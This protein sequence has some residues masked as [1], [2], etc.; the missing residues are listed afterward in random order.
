M[1]IAAFAAIALAVVAFVLS[2]SWADPAPRPTACPYCRALLGADDFCPRCAR[3]VGMSATAATNRFWGDV[4]YLIQ[5]PPSDTDLTISSKLSDAGIVEETVAS[6][7]GERYTWTPGPDGAEVEGRV[8]FGRSSKESRL[9]ATIRDTVLGNRLV[10]REILGEISGS[11]D[12]Y[13]RRTLDYVYTTDGL[14]SA[15]KFGTWFFNSASD[16]KKRPGEW[17]KHAVGEIALVRQDGR[18]TRIETTVREGRRSLRGEPEYMEPKT[19][20]ESAQ[21][22]A[23]GAIDRLVKTTRPEESR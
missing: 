2:P 12:A 15:V 9:Q 22:A 6:R 4:P 3:L 5:F 14:L 8:S 16:R 10:A 7:T 21:R 18:L 11:P 17:T 1:K 20:V 13:L 19:K 23:S